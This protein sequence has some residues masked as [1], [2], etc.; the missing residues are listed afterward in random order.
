MSIK[1]KLIILFLAIA[2]IPLIFIS[3]LTFANYKQSLETVRLSALKNEAAFKAG[4]VERYFDRLKTNVEM[5]Q[6]FFNIKKNLPVLIRSAGE[7]AGPVFASAVRELDGQLFKMQPLLGLTDIMLTDANG[8]IVYSSNPGHRAEDFLNSL[9]GRGNRGFEEG[10]KGIFFS[11]L[12]S[13]ERNDLRP[14]M[15]VNAPATDDKG[16][17][18][19]VIAFEV[20]MAPVYKLLEDADGSSRTGETVLGKKIGN[21]VV[22]LNP[23]RFDPGSALRRRV[24]IGGAA[25]AA[26]QMAAQGGTGCGRTIDYRG[27]PVIVAWRYIPFLDWGVVAKIDAEEAFAE[28]AKLRKL[29]AVILGIIS[30]LAGVMAV[31]VSRSISGPIQSLA[32]GIEIIGSGN[33]DHKV[34]T[35]LGD[36]IGRLSR[37]FD[38]MTAEQK[39]ARE[40]LRRH[41][42]SLEELVK[43]RTSDLEGANRDLARSNESLEQ[44]AYVASHDLQEPLRVMSS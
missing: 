2:L 38:V 18:I 1:S 19:G 37:A 24:T 44:F 25:G 13:N 15:L 22:F 12:F 23:L 10:R 21:E 42:D 17:F 34:G 9:P 3:A 40:E 35:Q 27:K 33:L 30:L 4:A 5:S 39:R 32:K 26:I 41:R 14:G 28:I 6:S 31:S 29:V 20:D 8:R 11:D 43:E 7:P 36:E 16:G